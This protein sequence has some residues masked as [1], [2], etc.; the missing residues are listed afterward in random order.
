MNI[1]KCVFTKNFSITCVTYKKHRD[2]KDRL[3]AELLTLCGY[4]TL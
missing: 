1:D 2:I 3:S 4:M